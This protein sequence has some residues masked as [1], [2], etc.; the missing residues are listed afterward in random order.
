M[1][2]TVWTGSASVNEICTFD[3]AILLRD[4]NQLT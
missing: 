1:G 2:G 4:V 3:L